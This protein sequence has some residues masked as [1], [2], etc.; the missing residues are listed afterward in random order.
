MSPPPRRPNCCPL[1][2]SL[3]PTLGIK[4]GPQ[5]PA[6]V[7]A[8]N[9]AGR[10]LYVNTTQAPVTVSFTGVKTGLLSHKPYAGTLALAP[11]GVEIVQ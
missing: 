1:V 5:T 7:V 3:Y 11:Y 8:R 4:R 6:G 10:T 9:V 2:R